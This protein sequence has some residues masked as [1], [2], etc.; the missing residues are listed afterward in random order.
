MAEAD[1]AEQHGD[2][3]HSVPNLKAVARR[4][5]VLP[6]PGSAVPNAV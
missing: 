5:G 1:G 4:L 3:L 2:A 6:E